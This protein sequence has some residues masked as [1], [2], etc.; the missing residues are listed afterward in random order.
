MFRTTKSGYMIPEPN[1]VEYL[2]VRPASRGGG[3]IVN[4]VVAGKTDTMVFGD[5]TLLTQTLM[6]MLNGAAL[7][8]MQEKV[9][10]QPQ[11]EVPPADVSQ[12]I[13]AGPNLAL[14]TAPVRS[15]GGET[16][17]SPAKRKGRPK[18]TEEQKAAAAAARAA[19]KANSADI[20]AAA[21]AA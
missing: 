13:K 16:G 1:S 19:K 15:A 17:G 9:Q 11:P 4:M 3:W 7:R 5:P 6:A 21:K 12:R 2:E 10:A 8:Q 20:P 18:M 14:K